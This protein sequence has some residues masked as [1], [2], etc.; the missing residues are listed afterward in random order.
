MNA[1]YYGLLVGARGERCEDHGNRSNLIRAL[2]LENQVAVALQDLYDPPQDALRTGV[3]GKF[4]DFGT[5]VGREFR[6]DESRCQRR[7]CLKLL[8]I[9]NWIGG[10]QSPQ[11]LVRNEEGRRSHAVMGHGRRGIEVKST[12]ILKA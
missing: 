12:L 10:C 9:G 2:I 4:R 1:S 3:E 7:P 5:G 6:E 8:Q 11:F